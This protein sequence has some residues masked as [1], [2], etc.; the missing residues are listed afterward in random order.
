MEVQRKENPPNETD[1]IYKIR[2]IQNL[3]RKVTDTILKI[4]LTEL[5]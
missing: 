3:S 4:T 5:I 1:K 2:C